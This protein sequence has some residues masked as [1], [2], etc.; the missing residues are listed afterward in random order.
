MIG[1]S[2]CWSELSSSPSGVPCGDTPKRAAR[3]SLRRIPVEQ[4]LRFFLLQDVIDQYLAATTPRPPIPL[5]LA[6]NFEFG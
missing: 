5:A 4:R 1:L 3:S 6:L 2:H